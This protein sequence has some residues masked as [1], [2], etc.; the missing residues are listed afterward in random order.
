MQLTNS[1]TIVFAKAPRPGTTKTRLIPLLGADGAAALQARLVEHTLVTAKAAAVGSVALYGTPA[2]DEFLR[3]CA[4]R[5]DV[6]LVDQC[7]GDLGKRMHAALDNAFAQS[8]CVLLIGSDCPALT[9]RHLRSAE[10]ALADGHDAV[11]VP[12][13]DGGYALVG[14]T[15]IHSKLFSDI[16]WSTSRVMEATRTRL[17]ELGF[18][19]TELET[20]WDV[21]RPA[22]YVRLMA[23]G[24][25]AATG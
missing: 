6:P 9:V 24:L 17:R 20:L 18:N 4:G 1:C 19:W 25:V 10:R 14:L 3:T 22:D 11:F 12:T 21:D 8:A 13:E 16:C 15:R 5:Y 23:S 2:A 7:E